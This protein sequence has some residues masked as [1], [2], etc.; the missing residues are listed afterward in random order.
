[1]D[2]IGPDSD[3]QRLH[4]LPE[5]VARMNYLIAL[6]AVV[7]WL[8]PALAE[9]EVI[10]VRAYHAYV[11]KSGIAD[12]LVPDYVVQFR[13]PKGR[14][15]AIYPKTARAQ[16]AFHYRGPSAMPLS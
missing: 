15:W 6:V 16:T 13:V 1:M 4:D 5:R 7:L 14:S 11:N 2:S 8:R 9:D 12:W 10:E 3:D